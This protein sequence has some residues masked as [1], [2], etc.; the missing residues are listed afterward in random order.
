M[1]SEWMLKSIV[2]NVNF[3]ML[4]APR[5]TADSHAEI[6]GLGRFVIEGVR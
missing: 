1:V 2:Q 6:V 5:A 3:A 4:E